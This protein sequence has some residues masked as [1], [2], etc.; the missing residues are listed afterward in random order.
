[1]LSQHLNHTTGKRS[2]HLSPKKPPQKQRLPQRARGHTVQG[3]AAQSMALASVTPGNISEEGM[4]RLQEPETHRLPGKC[5]HKQDQN[6]GIIN[7]NANVGG[8][9]MGS[10]K[11]KSPGNL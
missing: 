9:F 3:S 8:I 11:Q 7:G 6:N 2:T 5:L 1:M 10:P 4:E